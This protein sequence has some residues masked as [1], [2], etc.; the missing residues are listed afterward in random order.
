MSKKATL[1]LFIRE[2]R[3]NHNEKEDKNEKKIT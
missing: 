1:C 3:I 2:Y